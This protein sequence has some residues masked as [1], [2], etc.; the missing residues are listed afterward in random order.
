MESA[1]RGKTCLS[2]AS[3]FSRRRN[4]APQVA[5]SEAKGPRRR[6]A[7]SL[8]TFLLAKQKKVTS[9]RATPG[10][11]VKGTGG[12]ASA[13]RWSWIADQVHYCPEKHSHLQRKVLI[14][15]WFLLLAS[16]IYINQEY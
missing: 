16:R 11:V 2:A 12:Q 15:I 7:F 5:C 14:G 1:E 13:L 10:L 8:V 6:V 4:R 3:C 9:R